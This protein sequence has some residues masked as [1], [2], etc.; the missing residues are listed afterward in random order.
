MFVGQAEVR[1][2][3]RLHVA[4]AQPFGPVLAVARD[5][6]TCHVNRLGE[7]ILCLVE[8]AGFTQYPA[9]VG[10]TPEVQVVPLE[11]SR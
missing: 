3:L 10:E 7:Q 1:L 5:L 6:G 9:G 11:I 2:G 4:P 8:L